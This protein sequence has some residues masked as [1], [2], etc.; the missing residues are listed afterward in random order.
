MAV[1]TTSEIGRRRLSEGLHGVLKKAS[2]RRLQPAPLGQRYDV[3]L[4]HSLRSELEMETIYGDLV[5]EGLTVYVDQFEDPGMDPTLVDRD[6]AERLRVRLQHC[7]ALV[8]AYTDRVRESRWVPWELGYADGHGLPAAVLP[9]LSLQDEI[10]APLA[11]LDICHRQEYMSLY[12]Y[13]TKTLDASGRERLYANDGNAWTYLTLGEWLAGQTAFRV[14]LNW[15]TR[16][17]RAA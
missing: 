3:F 7:R 9:L 4:S 16:V 14:D 6:T 5:G 11:Q 8:V 2:A 10:A 15:K 17:L 1:Y 12:P 13:V